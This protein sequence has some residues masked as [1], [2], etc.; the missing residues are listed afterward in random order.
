MTTARIIALSITAFLSVSSLASS[1]VFL[2]TSA[3][4]AFGPKKAPAQA[5]AQP[6]NM[7][8]RDKW[9]LLIGVNRFSDSSIPALKFAQKSSAD[10]ARALKDT[11]AGHFSLDHV[12]VV[13]GPDASKAG[14]E[15]AF[16]E[17]LFK[18]ALP[19]DLVVIY[20]NSRL[21]KNQAGDAIVCANDTK[22][23]EPDKTGINLSELL[24]NARARVG[25]TH[26]ICMLDT[27]PLADSKDSAK[28]SHDLKWLA[29][30]S[31]LTVLSGAELFMPSSDDATCMQTYF[32][33]FFVEAL[34][35]GGGN[36]PL[37]MLAEYVWQKVQ[38]TTKTE[39]SAGQTPILAL[40]SEQ[41]Q[42]VSIPIGIMV[43][44]SLPPKTVAIGHPLETLAIKRP[45]I[46]A[47]TMTAKPGIKIQARQAG[48]KLPAAQP[49]AAAK[50]AVS[51]P[52][53][54]ATA[55]D[56]DEDDFDPNLDLRPYVAKIK[57]DI[58]KKWELPKGFESRK[59]TTLFSIMRDGSIENPSIVESSGNDN[60]DV[61]AISALHAAS[62]LDPLP[63]GAPRSVDIKYT[64]DWSSRPGSH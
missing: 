23:A 57:Q 36:F 27:S 41:S 58:L 60:V 3:V 22:A 17:W 62:P 37:A 26:M 24:R 59:V 51:K 47:P 13:N 16:N 19:D 6:E 61:S 52:K 63:K 7:E 46:V 56:D 25:S 64:F 48:A 38:E 29:T 5:A 35:T 12:L 43:R 55:A 15:Q 42:T 49:A 44:S 4:S 10:L 21:L 11:E 39:A 34:K 54:Q 53:A 30:S 1:S 31:N 2:T 28:L 18:K 32:S 33:H 40:P 45:D 20:I 8:I 14:I 50:P 9:A